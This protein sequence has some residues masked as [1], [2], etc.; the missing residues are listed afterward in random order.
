[1]ECDRYGHVLDHA[2]DQHSHL[3][4]GSFPHGFRNGMA[5]SPGDCPRGQLH[6]TAADAAEWPPRCEV[7]GPIPSFGPLIFWHCGCKRAI[8]HPCARCVWVV[9]Y[10]DMGRRELH[11]PDSGPA[12]Q[13]SGFCSCLAG[14]GHFLAS[15]GLL[16]FLLGHTGLGRVERNGEHTCLGALQCTSAHLPQLIAF[17]LGGANSRR[18]RPHAV[19]PFLVQPWHAQSRAV[20]GRVLAG[21][22]RSSFVLGHS[23]SEHP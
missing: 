15:A 5:A 13:N 23:Q 11:L 18:V 10:T 3:H 16:C 19:R 12:G 17:G 22:D 14:I 1:M 9:W 6:H 8:H 21:R 7:W 20:L 2:R 4:A